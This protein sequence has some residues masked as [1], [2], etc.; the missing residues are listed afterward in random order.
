MSPGISA[1]KSTAGGPSAGE[2]D[3][4]SPAGTGEDAAGGRPENEPGGGRAQ[5]LLES[6][7]GFQQRTPAV[8]VPV[9]VYKKFSDDESAK[10]ATLIS[11]Y[12]FLSVFPLL[13]VLATV[14]SRV[15]AN[16]QELADR[17]VSTAAGSFLSIGSDSGQVQP[18]NV[19]GFALVIGLLVTLWSGLGVANGMQDAMNTVYEVPKTERPGLL[20]RVLRSI[21]LLLVVGVGLPLT[22]LLQG[23]VGGLLP[24][25]VGNVLGIIAALAINT[26]LISVAFRRA[27]VAQTTWRGVLPGAV[28]AALAWAL[29]Q[30]VATDLLT[31]RVQGAQRTY[32]SFALVIGLLFWFLLLAQVTLYCA[33]L[34]VVL[35]QRL[36]P[37]SL[38]SL[39][40]ATADTPADA[41]AYS[42]Y[43][44]REK[45]AR[46]VDVTVDVTDAATSRSES[47]DPG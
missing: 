14:L 29:M 13:I 36:W 31:N 34:N 24:G 35:S 9:A 25:A 27:T 41:A 22:T 21:V 46:N 10:L 32:G 38:N 44:K 16:N 17:I 33:Q 39:V 6:V 42:K 8:G 19:A 2:R 7:D 4:G 47:R 26:A 11:Y 15:L 28:I 20:P 43:P 3:V 1:R 30:S 18:L 12:A 23:F 5:R 37:R 45:Q 40:Q